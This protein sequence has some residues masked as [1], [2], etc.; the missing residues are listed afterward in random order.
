MSDWERLGNLVIARR[1]ELG[2]RRRED[3][4]RDAGL[5]ERVLG[6]IESGRRESYH[7]R[8]L[9]AL[10]AALRWK[11]GS[12]DAILAGGEATE[13][14]DGETAHIVGATDEIVVRV[15]S[16]PRISDE[17][18][19]KI[20]RLLIDERRRFERERAARAEELMKIFRPDEV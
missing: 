16:D 1:I 15:M 2:Y 11:Q 6:D 17:D 5:S 13:R 4:G 14:P 3:F 9:L 8:T 20:V 18:K 12:V 7:A 10:Q 19:K